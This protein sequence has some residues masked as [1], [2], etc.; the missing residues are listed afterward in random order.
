[1][2]LIV[3]SLTIIIYVCTIFVKQASGQRIE[4]NYSENNH[5][6]NVVFIVQDKKKEEENPDKDLRGV[7]GTSPS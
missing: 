5:Q 1:M 2:L 4:I 6:R 7:K 3:A